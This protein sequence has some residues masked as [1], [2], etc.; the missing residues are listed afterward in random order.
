MATVL[1]FDGFE[2]NVNIKEILLENAGNIYSCCSEKKKMYYLSTFQQKKKKH[3]LP[4]ARV[5]DFE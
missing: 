4:V 1:Y 3:S 2:D 5:I